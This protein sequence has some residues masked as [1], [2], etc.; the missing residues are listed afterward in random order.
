MTTLRET[1]TTWLKSYLHGV[2]LRSSTV[3][4][5]KQ[6]ADLEQKYFSTQDTS[7]TAAHH[8]GQP[9]LTTTL[10]QTHTWMTPPPQF[11]VP[12]SYPPSSYSAPPHSSY[13]P[14]WSAPYYYPPPTIHPA[15]PHT[16]PISPPFLHSASLKL[17]THKSHQAP[18]MFLPHTYQYP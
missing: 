14:P 13:H 17:Y 2:A 6:A 15:Y 1:L 11:T 16:Y 8:L 18:L 9:V 3:D 10:S 5:T 12:V 4:E 7:T